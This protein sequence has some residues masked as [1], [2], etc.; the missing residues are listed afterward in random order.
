MA[1]RTS[2]PELGDRPGGLDALRARIGSLLER[3]AFG[4]P[5]WPLVAYAA[6]ALIAFAVILG[7]SRG[8]VL[9]PDE[10][11]F[12]L[13]S[14]QLDVKNAFEPY[15]GQ[16]LLTTKVLYRAIFEVFGSGYL[17]FR[18]LAATSVVSTVTL[19]YVYASRAVGR[20]AAL[21]PCL[22]LLLF[23]SDG[24]HVLAGNT[25]TVLFPIACGIGALLALDRGDRVGDGL[26][27]ALLCLAVVTFGT[28]LAMT[29]AVAVAILFRDDR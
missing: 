11:S 12:F 13:T 10:L 17:P 26:A 20:V 6:A 28:G 4:G 3:Q 29:V 1:S 15:G 22:V 7:L 24:L 18:V 25:F 8:M 23:G 19:L 27:C 21:A 5:A 9:S 16:L 14:P 2:V